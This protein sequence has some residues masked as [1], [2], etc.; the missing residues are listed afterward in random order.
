MTALFGILQGRRWTVAPFWRALGAALPLI[1]AA[2]IN[3]SSE[4][5]NTFYRIDA[6]LFD[7]WQRLS[8]ADE[9]SGEVIVVGID[10]E[11]IQQ[12]GRWPWN[13][14]VLAELVGLIEAAEPRSITLDLLLT[15]PGPYAEVNLYRAFRQ[16]APEA[17]AMLPSDPDRELAETIAAAPIALAVAGATAAGIDHLRDQTQC[18]D[19]DLVYADDARAFYV[20]CLLFPLPI[21][22]ERARAPAVTYTRQDLDGVV[23]RASAFVGQ[24]YLDDKGNVAHL[25]LTSMPVAALIACGDANPRCFAYDR[26]ETFDLASLNRLSGYT[27]RLTRA[28][29]PVPPPASMTPSLDLWLDYG[30]LL[31]LAEAAPG[32]DPGPDSTVSAAALFQ[33]A[34]TEAARLRDKHVFVGLT[35]IGAIDR[36]TTPLALESGSPGVLIQALAA[37]NLIA[38]RVLSSPQWAKD[39]L[40][41]F[42]IVL[43]A[44]ALAR[45]L[46]SSAPA[47]A[48]AGLLLVLA[49]I[50]VSWIAFE[51]FGLLIGGGTPAIGA[52]LAVSPVLYGRIAAIRRELA[53][54]REEQAATGARMDAARAIQLGSLPFSADF[55][56]IGFQT[57]ALCRPAQEVGGDFFEL[58]RLSDGRLFAAVGDVSGKGLEASLVT[59]LSKSISGAVTD[60]VEGALGDAFREISREFIRQAPREW[61]EEKGGFVTL[62]AARIDPETGEA[63]FACAGCAPPTVLSA[64]G[65][66]K[67]V[68]LPD[69]APLGWIEDARFETA[70]MRLAPGDTVLMFTDGVTEAETPEGG[71][72]GQAQAEDVAGAAN[73]EGA[74]SVVATLEAAVLAHQAG[75]APTDDTTILAVTWMG[76]GAGGRDVS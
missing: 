26:D 44:L 52:L 47:M 20:E 1:V 73:A 75:G 43:A 38:G 37:D 22:E 68:E 72:F 76:A 39:L 15:E 27:L 58:F 69:V 65:E 8:S 54:A 4:A 28:E 67:P 63:E 59:A 53:D 14:D 35:R 19:P 61:R 6:R 40:T 5:I 49:P 11:A 18:A 3:F 41:V 70:R 64:S 2:A 10:G 7:Q 51:S 62:V 60:R 36:H 56:E 33:K 21:F 66:K 32:S 29:G 57:G 74:A 42:L 9:P 55:A 12:K 48:A 46:L 25:F 45:F 30:A 50:V 16:N 34:E 23:R 24:P 17:V 31:A 13:R 71:L